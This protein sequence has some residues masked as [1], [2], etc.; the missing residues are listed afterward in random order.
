MK[1]LHFIAALMCAVSLSA[2]ASEKSCKWIGGNEGKFG[3][4]LVASISEH[5]VTISGH[6][7]EGAY[8]RLNGEDVQGQDGQTY[9]SYDVGYNDG[10]NRVLVDWVLLESGTRGLLKLRGRGEGFFEQ[11]FACA[12]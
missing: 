4:T 11:K 9:Y 2:Y 8:P 5:Q 10:A 1:S 6:D 7:W 12:D 3:D